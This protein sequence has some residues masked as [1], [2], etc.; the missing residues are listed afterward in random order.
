M[1]EHI[2]L[3]IKGMIIGLGKIIPGVSGSLLA[4]SLGVYE[5]TI[6]KIRYFFKDIQ[7]N[8]LYFFFLGL[9]ILLS[10]IFGSK[11]ILYFLNYHYVLTI[12]LFIG[13]ILGIVPSVHKKIKHRDFKYYI[14]MIL[15]LIFSLLLLNVKSVENFIYQDNF[16]SNIQILL[17]GFLEAFTMI[18]P[19]ISGTAIFLILGYYEFLME[20]FS[21][22]IIFLFKEPIMITLFFSSFLFGVYFVSGLI[23]FMLSKH[24]KITYAIISGFGYSSI[25][26]LLKEVLQKLQNPLELILSIFLMVFGYI[27]SKK[28][29]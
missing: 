29:E 23:H 6:Y 10:I 7:E 18:V 2:L 1:K 9:G 11:I 26:L 3:I 14:V 8:I 22:I 15:T 17:M 20:L 24:E 12:F 25:F 16:I 5:K 27:I 4:M 21:N 13:L 19:G 28:F